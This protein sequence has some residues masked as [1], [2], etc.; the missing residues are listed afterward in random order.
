[1]FFEDGARKAP[2][3]NPDRLLLFT[4]EALVILAKLSPAFMPKAGCFFSFLS[5]LNK[6]MDKSKNNSIDVIGFINDNFN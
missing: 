5:W 6:E 2:N 3:K 1:M 4:D